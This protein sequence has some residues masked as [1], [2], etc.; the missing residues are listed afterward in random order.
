MKNLIIRWL[1]LDNVLRLDDSDF[2]D[3]CVTRLLAQRYD[4]EGMDSRV[5]DMDYL[6]Q[7]LESRANRWDDMADKVEDDSD[8]FGRGKVESVGDRRTELVAGYELYFQL[9]K[10]EF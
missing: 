6:T 7:D 10:E 1:G 2:I 3:D 5:D 4:L 8:T 9:V